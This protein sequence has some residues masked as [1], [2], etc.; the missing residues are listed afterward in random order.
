L[1][2]M[3]PTIIVKDGKLRAVLG[4]PGGPTIIT[5]V[6]Q[7]TMQIIDHQRTLE[8]AVAA[9]RIHH[10][11]QPDAIWH[12]E[13]LPPDT[14]A[15]LTGLGHSLKMRPRIGH[16]NCIE[17]DAASGSLTAVADVKRDGGKASAY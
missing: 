12:E 7:I 3:S 9:T 13:T 11:W 1:S 15:A 8:Q 17:V 5:T 10:Q 16:A 6:A 14:A 4:S 2:S